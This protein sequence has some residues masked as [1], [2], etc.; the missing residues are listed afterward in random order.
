[1]IIVSIFH[2][3]ILK[4]C[5]Y[6]IYD[7]ESLEGYLIDVGDA[8]P[9]ID[10]I[11]T[12]GIDLKAVLLTHPHFDH[13]YG[14][15]EIVNA[16]PDIRIYCSSET[17][18][19]LKDEDINMSYMYL[20][21]EFKI[22]DDSVFRLID[23]AADVRCFNKQIRIEQ[24]QGHDTGC[25]AFIIENNIFTGDSYTPFAPV[26]YNWHRCNKEM[27][28]ESEKRLISIIQNEDLH[29]YPGHYQ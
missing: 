8:Q 12:H 24:C 26:T 16:Y 28:L 13:V 14:I 17:L 15:N 19:G 11:Q 7:E 25:L 1:M 20:E 27:A 23:E 6:C 5:S 4:S 3:S 22:P 10:F 2:N 29:V 21:D 9:I 18:D